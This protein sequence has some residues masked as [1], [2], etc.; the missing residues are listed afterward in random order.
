M[1]HD[2]NIVSE[3]DVSEDNASLNATIEKQNEI[4]SNLQVELDFMHTE[5]DKMRKQH[6]DEIEKIT[7]SSDAKLLEK[8]KELAATLSLVDKKTSELAEVIQKHNEICERANSYHLELEE[9]TNSLRDW[10]AKTVGLRDILENSKTAISNNL[11]LWLSAQLEIGTKPS[12]YNEVTKYFSD[13]EI[14]NAK[15]I[16]FD[17]CGG[18]DTAIGSMKVREGDK[19]CR[20][21]QDCDDI[22]EAM[23]ILRHGGTEPLF[24]STKSVIKQLPCIQ[25]DLVAVKDKIISHHKAT[26]DNQSAIIDSLKVTNVSH[27]QITDTVMSKLVNNNKNGSIPN[28]LLLWIDIQRMSTA[29]NIWKTQAMSHFT[30]E[31][32]LAAK[33]ELWSQC[34]EHRLGKLINRQGTSKTKAELEDISTALKNLAENDA[35]PIFLGSSEMIRKTPIFNADTTNNSSDVIAN[36]LKILEDMLS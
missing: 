27:S 31:E 22:V 23:E 26:I 24:V 14:N 16:L 3:Q 9:K 4:M 17:V 10:N 13:E 6:L 11:L 25:A 1:E 32:I 29:E 2:V 18:I 35:M 8:E 5:N 19:D 28:A 7:L 21:Q 30:A 12:L 34:G 15:A 36:R 20:E 33:N